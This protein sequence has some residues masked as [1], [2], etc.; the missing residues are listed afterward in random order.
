LLALLAS[1]CG[2][3]QAS[4]PLPPGPQ[5]VDVQ[6]RDYRFVYDRSSIAPGRTV[7]Q[8]RNTGDR[9]HELGLIPLPENFPPLDAELR[10]K[11][12]RAVALLARLQPIGPDTS[13]TFAVNLTPGR[14]GMVCF[15]TAPDGTPH[16]LKGMN[17]EFRVR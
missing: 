14:Y 4:A 12:S 11:T 6:L 15:V 5:V 16:A 2:A 3:E 8:V 10:S 17:S 9:R 7:F 13:G 1:S